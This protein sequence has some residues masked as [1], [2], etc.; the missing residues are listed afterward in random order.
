M[1]PPGVNAKDFSDALK[2]FEGAVGKEWV[3]T[4]DEDVALYRDA[5][6]PFWGEPEE[7]LASAA[8]APNT[9][10]EVQAVMKT[11]NEYKIPVYPISTGKNLGYGGSAPNLSGSVVLDLKR[12]NRILDV[13]ERNHSALVEPGVSYFDLYR[14]IQERKLKL[15]VDVPD[16][17]WGSPVGNSLDHGGGYLQP[18]Y[19]NH[20]DSHCG[21]EVVLA[22]GD[23]LRTGMGAMPGAQTWQQYK[24]GFGPWIDGMFSQSNFGVV[25]KMGFWLMPEPDA[26]LTGTVTVPGY[27]DLVPLIDIL[28]FLENSGVSNGM[29]GLGSP[30][31]GG[32]MMP[33]R[34]PEVTA[35]LEKEGVASPALHK[36]AKDKDI[37]FWSCTVKFY[38]PAKAIRA[39]WEYAQEKFSAIAGAKFKDDEFYKFPLTPDQFSKVHK[40]E[41]GIPSLEMFSIGARSPYNPTPTNGHI[42]FSPIIPRTGEAVLEVNKVFA[43]AAKDYGLP[44]LS[45][46]LPTT[47][48]MRAFV[49]LFGFPIMHDV[50]TNKK[51]RETFK[52]VIQVAAEHG[53]GEYRTAPAFQ[54]AVMDTYSFNNHALRRFHETVKDAVDPNG[55]ISAGRYG[56][57][58][59][60]LRSKA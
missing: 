22:N 19:R 47:Y 35:L 56:I 6:S 28:T 20:F 7:R 2:Q 59:Q 12:M 31:L 27:E 50:A 11:A 15:W 17:G 8:V 13:S 29:P 57:W 52:Q 14:H 9:V 51:N 39:Q 43:Q 36:Y 25:T 16:P 3:F 58:P 26:Y 21:M 54:D 48:W 42:W 60:H 37:P 24:F 34:S 55:I 33:Q 18:M 49:F 5:Y 23:L 38:G 10:E 32:F 30:I 44:L 1:Q 53:W 40:P 41:M 4:S 46:S 45:F